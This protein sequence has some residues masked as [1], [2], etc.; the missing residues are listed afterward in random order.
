MNQNLLPNFLLH[1][2]E[3]NSEK[4]TNYLSASFAGDIVIMLCLPFQLYTSYDNFLQ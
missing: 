4:L 2:R 1:S 3:H